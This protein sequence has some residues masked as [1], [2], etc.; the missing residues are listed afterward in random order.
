MT[1]YQIWH[2]I[3]LLAHAHRLSCSGLAKLSGL[4]PTIFNKSKRFSKYNQPRWPSTSSIAK[5]LDAT[6]V[7]IM[8]FCKYITA[9]DA[10]NTT[11]K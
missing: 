8:D 5:I 6:G 4:D 2:A 1:H 10:S 11:D 7:S 9:D 3:D